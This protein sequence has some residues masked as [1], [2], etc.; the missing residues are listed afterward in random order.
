[1]LDASVLYE[2]TAAAILSDNLPARRPDWTWGGPGTGAP[3]AVCELPV[4]ESQLEHEFEMQVAGGVENPSLTL[5]MH[6][7]CSAVWN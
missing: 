1:M 2:K 5:H 6:I 7:R 3:C 4:T